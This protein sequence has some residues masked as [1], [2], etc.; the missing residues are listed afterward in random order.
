MFVLKSF[1][2]GMI[3]LGIAFLIPH[4]DTVFGDFSNFSPT[5]LSL[6]IFGL[7]IWSMY[8]FIEPATRKRVF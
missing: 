4:L 6:I 8:Y 3:M 5:K 7:I 2:K 1:G